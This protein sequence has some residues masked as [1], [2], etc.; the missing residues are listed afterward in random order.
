M[1]KKEAKSL[2][3]SGVIE[4]A[5]IYA[6]DPDHGTRCIWLEGESLPPY[7]SHRLQLTRPPT[8]QSDRTRYFAG[9][10]TAVA[11]LDALGWKGK[12]T[13]DRAFEHRLRGE[14]S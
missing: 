11:F 9:V 8:G 2:I 6:P 4:E 13:L 1:N 3:A 14:Q 12:I 7:M 5:I 10:D